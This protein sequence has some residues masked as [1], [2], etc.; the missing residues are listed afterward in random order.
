[1]TLYPLSAPSQC[2]CKALDNKLCPTCKP[3]YNLHYRLAIDRMWQLG[4]DKIATEIPFQLAFKKH[5]PEILE[6]QND[7]IQFCTDAVFFAFEFAAVYG[8]PPF[9]CYGYKE[10]ME[11]FNEKGLF[12]DFFTPFDDEDTY[13]NRNVV[14]QETYDARH[15]AAGPSGP[16]GKRM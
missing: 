10:K 15:S 7:A 4:I 13:S 16:S 2:T 5:K 14:D 6:G 9:E 3:H 1:M 8:C 11:K 12:V